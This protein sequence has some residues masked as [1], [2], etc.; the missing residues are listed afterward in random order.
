[1]PQGRSVSKWLTVRDPTPPPVYGVGKCGATGWLS[2][3]PAPPAPAA[4]DL[5]LNCLIFK[6]ESVMVPCLIGLLSGGNELV[7]GKPLD[8]HPAQ[9]KC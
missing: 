1:M 6:V 3:S 8:R 5:G 4:V 7:Q 9:N 2:T